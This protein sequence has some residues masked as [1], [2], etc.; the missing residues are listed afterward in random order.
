MPVGATVGAG[1]TNNLQVWLFLLIHSLHCFIYL[2]IF[3]NTFCLQ[4]IIRQ[5]V[6]RRTKQ[7]GVQSVRSH[8]VCSVLQILTGGKT[9]TVLSILDAFQMEV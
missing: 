1:G 8:F 9:E 4:F 2:F 6:F 7:G 5:F 3:L